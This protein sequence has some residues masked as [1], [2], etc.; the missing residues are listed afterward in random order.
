MGLSFPEDVEIDDSGG[1]TAER[2]M[3]PDDEQYGDMLKGEL[4]EEVGTRR[5]ENVLKRRYERR[6]S[7]VSGVWSGAPTHVRQR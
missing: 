6:I 4:L 3:T 1:V 5:Y 7:Y 2:G